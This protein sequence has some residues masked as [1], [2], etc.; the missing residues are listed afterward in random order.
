MWTK[1]FQMYKL[2][3]EKA[4]EQKT[5]LPTSIGSQRKQENSRKISVYA[6]LTKLKLLT[7]WITTN[8][9]KLLKRW[10]HQC[11]LTASWETCHFMANRWGNNGNSERLYF[12]GLQ[13]HGRWWLQPWNW[14]TFISWRKNYDQPRQH[15][16][17]QRHYFTNKKVCLVKAM[18]FLVVMYECERWTI[19]KAE[20]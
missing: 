10:E 17:K 6:L 8:S 19:K 1:N 14:K 7:A 9:G 15:I 4:E 2:D 13:N 3:L 11:T 18:V 16:K 12:G 5:K 20:C